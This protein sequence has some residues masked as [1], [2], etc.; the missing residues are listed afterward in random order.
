MRT[1]RRRIA[2]LAIVALLF[3][4]MVPMTIPVTP[5]LAST[6]SIMETHWVD[7]W[8]SVVST[9]YDYQTGQPFI[10]GYYGWVGVDGEIDFPDHIPDLGSDGSCAHSSGQL[11]FYLGDGSWV[12]T[13]W[14]SGCFTIIPTCRL[15]DLGAYVE[16]D[17]L[18][19]HTYSVF[20]TNPN[21]G[22]VQPSTPII[23][24]IE[25]GGG[26]W[27]TYWMY[28]VRTGGLCSPIPTSGE[29]WA[30]AEV[31]THVD[32]T[33]VEM[34]TTYY[35]NANPYTN[36]GLRIKGANGFVPWTNS[37][38]SYYT[39]YYDEHNGAPGCGPPYNPK[40]TVF[41]NYATVYANY[42]FGSGGE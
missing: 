11:G 37:L 3:L 6:C 21:G 23:F 15:G 41:Y 20:D 9:F 22:P 4:A 19:T 27:N 31:H 30:G 13:G 10:N 8:T 40:C 35:G 17:N 42:R 39:S 38:S 1:A 26:C 18:E 24:M 32:D 33:I 14:Y 36:N 12:Q 29:A 7:Q 5:A 25:W 16:M 2:Q 34:P 28:N